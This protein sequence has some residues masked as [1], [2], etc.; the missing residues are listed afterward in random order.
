MSIAP[1]KLAFYKGV[2]G[3]FGAIQFQLSQPH[4][5]CPVCKRKDFDSIIP[6]VCTGAKD[7]THDAVEMKSREGCLFMEIT[8]AKGPNDYDWDNKIVMAL[9]VH[10]MSRV[11]YALETTAELTLDHDP[12]AKTDRQGKIHKLLFISSPKGR[13]AGFFFSVS[14]KDNETQKKIEHRLGLSAAEVLELNVFIRAAIP[15][16]LNW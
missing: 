3:K 7:K 15:R 6:K 12:G 10:D 8:S 14:Q 1:L 11:L 4:Y 2:T 5:Y 16:S 9:S 13:E